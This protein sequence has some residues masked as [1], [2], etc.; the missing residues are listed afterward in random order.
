M[1][2]EPLM[3]ER[4]GHARKNDADMAK[5]HRLDAAPGSQLWDA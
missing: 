2:L 1:S 4:K 5:G 3:T